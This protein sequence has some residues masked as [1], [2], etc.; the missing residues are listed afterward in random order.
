MHRSGAKTTKHAV[1]SMKAF[2]LLSL[3]EDNR[4]IL[5][6]KQISVKYILKQG[7]SRRKGLATS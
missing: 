7:R 1:Y 3:L 5:K 2:K 6:F 4:R